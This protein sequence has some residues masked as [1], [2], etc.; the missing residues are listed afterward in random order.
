MDG[1]TEKYKYAYHFRKEDQLV[2]RYDNAPDPRAKPFDGFPH[3]RHTESGE[4]IPSSGMD[5]PEILDR[6]Q[7]WILS[8]RET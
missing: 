2:F 1:G 7:D 6:V 5:F 4:I 3:H 8:G